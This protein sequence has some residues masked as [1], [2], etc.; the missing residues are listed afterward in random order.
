MGF[1]TV[2]EGLLPYEDI[3]ASAMEELKRIMSPELLNRVDDVVVFNALS[4][5]EV[6]NILDIQLAELQG[7]LSEKNIVLDMKAKARDFLVDNGYE[8]SM[9]AR[10]MRR[11]LQRQVEDPLSV[12]LLE[13]PEVSDAENAKTVVLDFDGE[14]LSLKLKKSRSK[15][16]K[17]K[18][19]LSV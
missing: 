1:S 7:R 19:F 9:G 6:S 10:P 15:P 12:L 13:N 16:V 17:E 8:P 2:K 3:K 4:R 5:E 14:K 11:L 18:E